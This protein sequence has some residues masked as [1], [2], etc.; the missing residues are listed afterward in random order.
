MQ[1]ILY[2]DDHAD[3]LEL[4]RA[5]LGAT[6]RR[7]ICAGTGREGLTLAQERK[8]DLILL[9]LHLRDVGGLVVLQRLKE[10]VETQAI[11]VIVLSTQSIEDTPALQGGLVAAYVRKP[12]D[13]PV[14]LRLAERILVD[15][16]ER[17]ALR[18]AAGGMGSDSWS[19][20]CTACDA[21]WS[22]PTG[23]PPH[24]DTRCLRCD[25]PLVL[26]EA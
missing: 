11:P 13:P 22:R 26:I 4:G 9:D 2:V 15:R 21:D 20:R 16:S 23:D 1:T 7:V 5:L 14:F 3:S 18:R 19:W 25:G 12:V 6:R 17:A 10:D 8:P 24:Q